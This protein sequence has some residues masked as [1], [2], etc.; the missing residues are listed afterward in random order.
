MDDLLKK[1]VTKVDIEIKLTQEDKVYESI[2]KWDKLSDCYYGK[3]DNIEDLISFQGP[4]PKEVIRA[5][6]DAI[7]YYN[8]V[9]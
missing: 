8:S 5:F 6:F 7:E 3:I 9:K 2:I 1:Y 4:T